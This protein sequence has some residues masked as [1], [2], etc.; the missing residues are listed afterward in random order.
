MRKAWWILIFIAASLFAALPIGCGGEGSSG[1]GNDTGGAGTG[2]SGAAS[3][4]GGVIIGGSGPGANLEIKPATAEIIVTNGASAPID[5]DCLS[6]GTSVSAKWTIDKT[7]VATTDGEGVATAVGDLGGEVKVTCQY[8]KDSKTAILT[9]KIVSDQNPGM[10][11]DPDIGILKGD[12]DPDP[13]IAWL[14]PYDK[15]VFPKGI[16]PPELMWNGATA[17]DSYLI[18]YKTKFVDVTVFTKADPPSRFLPDEKTWRAVT[19]SGKGEDV[20]LQ[21]KRLVAGSAKATV[22]VD[23]SWKIATGAL[24]GLVYYW[25]NSAGRILR[26]DPGKGTPPEDFL[27]TAGITNPCSTCHT[28]SANGLTLVMGGDVPDSVFDLLNN[29]TTLRLGNIGKP[30]REWAMPAVS[31]DGK[32]LI[33]NNA[34]NIPGPPGS[35]QGDGMFNPQTGEKLMGTGLDGVFLGMPA[36]S[37]SGRLIAAVDRQSLGLIKYS[38]DPMTNMVSGLTTLVEAGPD[39]SLNAICFP[40]VAPTEKSNEFSDSTWV[41]YHRG[42]YPNSLDT[43]NGFGDLF[44]A[45]MDTPGIEIRLRSAGGDDYPFAAGDRD[46][47]YNYEPTFAPQPAGGYHWI[48]FT[49]RRT[50]GNRLVGG[51]NDVKQLWIAAVDPNPQPGID[52]SHPAFWIPGQDANLNMRGFWAQKN[53]LQAGANCTVDSECCSGTCTN[54]VCE[55][56]P[57]EG[58]SAESDSCT[59]DA[60]CCDPGAQCKAGECV[61]GP[62]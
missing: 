9:V 61:V 40:S 23:H 47:H 57:G 26:I 21:V 3:G 15:T 33:E 58:C 19:E 10:I 46:R 2:G 60:D 14:Y 28:V 11:P 56:E 30:V 51:K 18:R 32:V 43:R 42:Q 22:V 6:G 24:R 12:G 53:C 54:G 8:G 25:S 1:G 49:S 36:F 59:V 16:Y 62:N 55:S 52:P 7:S 31:P 27:A 13:T 34:T 4:S 37:P 50:Y 17:G 41:T 48:V 45:S 44:L 39:P 5:F 38:F 20:Q 35:P 29:V